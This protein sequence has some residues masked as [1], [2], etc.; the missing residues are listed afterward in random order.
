MHTKNELTTLSLQ[1]YA[2][3]WTEGDHIWSEHVAMST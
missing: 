1:I 2:L 3:Y